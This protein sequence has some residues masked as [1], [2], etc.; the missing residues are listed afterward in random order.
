MVL[1][2]QRGVHERIQLLVRILADEP[3][4]EATRA[5]CDELPTGDPVRTAPRSSFVLDADR[6][7]IHFRIH[8]TDEARV[9]RRHAAPELAAADHGPGVPDGHAAT[10]QA[11]AQVR[12]D[13]KDRSIDI[14]MRG[15]LQANSDDILP[16]PGDNPGT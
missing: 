8:L 14:R 15:K 13:P 4:A 1:G 16:V 2:H 9:A 12:I 10:G 5:N 3:R 6:S 7:R 11:K